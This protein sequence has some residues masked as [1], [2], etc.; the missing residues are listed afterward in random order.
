MTGPQL[1]F[2]ALVEVCEPRSKSPGDWTRHAMKVIHL[3]PEKMSPEEA[4]AAF[5]RWLYDEPPHE[6]DGGILKILTDGK[7]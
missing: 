6:Q 3:V 7:E 1:E 2:I 4:A 5:V